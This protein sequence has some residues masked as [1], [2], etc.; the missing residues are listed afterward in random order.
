MEEDP[1]TALR[2][3]NRISAKEF[4]KKRKAQLKQEKTY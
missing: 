4:I 2:E 3:K 1:K